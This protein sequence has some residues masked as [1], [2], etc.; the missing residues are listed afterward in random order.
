MLPWPPSTVTASNR[1]NTVIRDGNDYIFQC[2]HC[3][4]FCIVAVGDVR[5]TI[6]R[7]AVRIS[8][9]AFVNPHASREHCEEWIRKGLVYGCGKPFIMDGKKVESCGYI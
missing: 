4:D 8:D 5:C 2:P 1:P 6:F 3:G 7:H 9:F